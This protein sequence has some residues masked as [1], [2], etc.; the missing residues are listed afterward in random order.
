[1][2]HHWPSSPGP[3]LLDFIPR[4]PDLCR[5]K[6]ECQRMSHTAPTKPSHQFLE[7][8]QHFEQ[9]HQDQNDAHIEP[10]QR[11]LLEAEL[12]QRPFDSKA[13]EREELPPMQDYYYEKVHQRQHFLETVDMLVDRLH[14]ART[15]CAA[16]F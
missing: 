10:G 6:P 7:V 11:R 8:G 5:H 14:L 4:P 1:M 3:L 12:Q 16:G 9:K 15:V 13:E 2:G